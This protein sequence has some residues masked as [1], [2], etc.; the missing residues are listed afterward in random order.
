L[1]R[2]RAQLSRT[3]QINRPT[4]TSILNAETAAG[5]YKKS[6]EVLTKLT[7]FEEH[8]IDQRKQ[9]EVRVTMIEKHLGLDKK[10]AGLFLCSVL[11]PPKCVDWRILHS[12]L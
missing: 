3:Y 6:I 2:S 7:K 12:Y 4:S 1:A 8:E 10:I 11:S 9:I 5:M